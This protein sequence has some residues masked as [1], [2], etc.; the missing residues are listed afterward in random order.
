MEEVVDGRLLLLVFAPP[1][2]DLGHDRQEL[3]ELD[4]ARPVLV[5]GC[6]R[7]HLQSM[8]S[9]TSSR[10]CESPRAMKGSSSSSTPMEP[11]PFSSRELKYFL[12]SSRA[13]SLNTIRFFFPCFF[14]QL[15]SPNPEWKISL[16]GSE[17]SSFVFNS[18]IVWGSIQSVSG[19]DRKS[20]V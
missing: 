15:R 8:S 20:V 6:V 4:L 19:L 9:W 1:L 2:A 13:S 11:V 10:V 7:P 5:D 16:G 14:S 12:S 3:V 18:G 17:I